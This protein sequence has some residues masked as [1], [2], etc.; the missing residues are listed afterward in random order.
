MMFELQFQRRKRN[1]LSWSA[2]V[3]QA[4]VILL[5]LLRKQVSA[6]LVELVRRVETLQ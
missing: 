1:V 5:Y 6:E 3:F 2:S 4:Y